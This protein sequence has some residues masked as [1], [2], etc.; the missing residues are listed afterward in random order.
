MKTFKILQLACLILLLTDITSF[1]PRLRKW[2]LGVEGGCPDKKSDS[3][4]ACPAK[5]ESKPS[6]PA[7]EKEK[8]D[9]KTKCSIDKN[10]PTNPSNKQH[11]LEAKATPQSAPQTQGVTKTCTAKGCQDSKC[12]DG[13]CKHVV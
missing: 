5:K 8:K 10:I 12:K 13:K 2:R 4:S 7:K 3:K 9:G 1:D 11:I 6:C